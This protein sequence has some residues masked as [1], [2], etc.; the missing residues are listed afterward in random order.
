MFAAAAASAALAVTAYPKDIDRNHQSRWR[1]LSTLHIP[2]LM[3][4]T[5]LKRKG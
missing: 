2:Y 5:S 4:K 3:T 1:L